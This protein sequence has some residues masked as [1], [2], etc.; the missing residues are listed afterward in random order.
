MGIMKKKTETS[1]GGLGLGVEGQGLGV[2]GLEVY[3][4]GCRV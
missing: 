3:G 2:K 1:V 4:S